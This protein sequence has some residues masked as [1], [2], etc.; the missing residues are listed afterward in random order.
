MP[1]DNNFQ[2][3]KTY[4][5]ELV[6]GIKV[7]FT[8]SAEIKDIDKKEVDKKDLEEILHNFAY[9]SKNFYLNLGNEINSK[10]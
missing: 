10:L 2:F 7:D 9:S 4:Q 5:C 1:V 3:S 8:I 6:D